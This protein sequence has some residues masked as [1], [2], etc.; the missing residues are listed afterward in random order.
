MIELTL[1]FPLFKTE[2]IVYQN[3]LYC[4]NIKNDGNL[5]ENHVDF[6]GIIQF[7]FAHSINS[8]FPIGKVSINTF[9]SVDDRLYFY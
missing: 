3:Y 6:G 2:W 5:G 7:L 4:L 8:S 9:F 1:C